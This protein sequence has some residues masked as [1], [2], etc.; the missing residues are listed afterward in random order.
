MRLTEQQIEAVI[1]L[2]GPE[3]YSHFVKAVTDWEEAWGLWND[4]W[5]LAGT[6]EG[7]QVFPLWPAKEY[8]ERCAIK[9]WEGYQPEPISL[10]DL[11]SELLPKLRRDGVLPGVFFTPFSKG[12]TPPAEQLLADLREE[13]AKYE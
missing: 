6:Q 5:A 11:V 3:R 4:G 8:A 13:A 9:E 12:V 2:S 7:V 10:E 1:A